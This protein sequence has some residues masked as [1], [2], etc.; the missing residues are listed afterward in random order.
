LKFQKLFL[1]DFAHFWK[2]VSIYVM[3][4]GMPVHMEQLASCRTGMKFHCWWYKSIVC[5][6]KTT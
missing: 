1:V 5:C 2:A 6:L 4:I 3:I